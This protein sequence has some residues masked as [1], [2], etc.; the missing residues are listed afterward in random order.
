MREICTSGSMGGRWK[1]AERWKERG[2]EGVG[3]EHEKAKG[4]AR[5]SALIFSAIHP[6]SLSTAPPLD[7]TWTSGGCSVA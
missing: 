1:R 6:G 4:S 5:V 2:V 3:P 7:P